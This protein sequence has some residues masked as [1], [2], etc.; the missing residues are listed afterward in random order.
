MQQKKQERKTVALMML[1]L[2][3][4]RIN[5]IIIMVELRELSFH[6]FY[7]MSRTRRNLQR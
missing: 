2:R 4:A 1:W 6:P 7:L 5:I 3:L